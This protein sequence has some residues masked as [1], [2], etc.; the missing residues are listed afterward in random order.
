MRNGPY[1][2]TKAPEN[3][4]GKKYRGKYVY[5]HHLVWWQE[6]GEV[7]DTSVYLLHH[8]DENKHNNSFSN[9]AKRVRSEH[10]AEHAP[11]PEQVELRCDWCEGTFIR[12]ARQHRSKVKN[13][14]K[15]V[16]CSR[17]HQVKYQWEHQGQGKK[18]LGG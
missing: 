18:I 9:L 2:L 10:S 1:I 6:T 4:P 11:T 13:D 5:E 7:V 15:H 3:Y 17:S 14:Y 8:L 16:F 12:N